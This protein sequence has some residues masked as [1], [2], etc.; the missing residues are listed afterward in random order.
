MSNLKFRVR[1]KMPTQERIRTYYYS[2]REL[3][4][5]AIL[6]GFIVE[7]VDLYSSREDKN[8]MEV[9]ENDIMAY[10]DEMGANDVGLVSYNDG[11]Y[12]CGQNLKDLDMDYWEVI[13]NVHDDKSLLEVD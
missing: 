5:Y 13:G 7:S 8:G 1:G 2:L 10:N 6:R 11:F 3:M 9:C 4:N 12:L